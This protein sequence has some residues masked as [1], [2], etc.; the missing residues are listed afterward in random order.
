MEVA[1]LCLLFG[2][3]LTIRFFITDHDTAADKDRKRFQKGIDLYQKQTV[4]EAHTY[5]DD[6]VRQYPKSAI[7][8]AYRG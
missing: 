7:A 8:Y 5:F 6:A 3:Y 4:E 2:I 1:L